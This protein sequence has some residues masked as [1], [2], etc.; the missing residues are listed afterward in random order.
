LPKKP[1][2]SLEG[3][4]AQ[5]LTFHMGVRLQNR[6]LQLGLQKSAVAAHLGVAPSVYEQYELGEAQ[7][8]ATALAELVGLFKVPLFYFF[9]DLVYDSPETA[10]EESEPTAVLRVATHAD[11][12]AALIEDFHKLGWQEQ[13]YV[14]MLAQALTRDSGAA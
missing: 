4:R 9:Q 13:Q 11:R 10:S 3:A 1:N 14:L 8:P 2:A 6:R 7:V 12:V 5:S